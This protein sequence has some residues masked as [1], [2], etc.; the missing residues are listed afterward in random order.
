[1]PPARP[2]HPPLHLAVAALLLSTLLHAASAATSPEVDAL[3]AFKSS[4]AIPPAADP[5]FASWD[6]SA[7]TPCNFTGVTCRGSAVTALSVHDLN[8]SAES[9]PFDVLCGSLKSL[10]TLSLPSNALAGTIAGVDAC[11]GLQELTLPFNSFSGEIPDLSPLTGLRTLNLSTNAFSGSFPWSALAAMPGLQAL[12]AGDNPYLTPTKSFP[13]EITRLTNLTKLYLSAANIAGPIPAGIGRLTRL[14]DLE[15]ADN[16]LTGEIPPAIAQLV[17]LQSLELYNC[18]LAGA[19]PRGFG[20]LTKL[21]FFDASQNQLTGGLSELRSLT[22]LVS[23]Q[24]FY[25][26][27]SGEVPPEFGEFR[28]LVNLSLYNNSL[29]GEL[30]QKL[31]SWSAL[32]FIDVSTNLLTGPIPPDMCRRGTMLK[33]LMLENRFS[34]EIPATYAT[35]TTLQR[36][37]VSKNSLTG[38]VPEGI[39]AL[40]TAEIIDLEGNQFTGGIGDAI[41]KAASLTSLHLAGNKFSGAIPS[42]IGDAAKL[43]SIDVSSNELYGEIPASIGKLVHLESLD[44]AGNGISGAIPASLGS[45]SALSTMNLAGNKLTGAIPSEL[46]GTSLNLLDISSNELSGAV[47]AILAELK[48][49]YLNLSDNRLDG[50]VPAGLAISA[51][52][53]SFQ[54]NPGLCANNGAGFLR[55]CTPGDGG[56]SGSTART[57]VTCLLAGMAVLLAVLGVAIFIKKRRQH[58]EA[59]AMAGAGKLLFAKKGSW[60]VKSFRMMAFDE[61]E[62]VGGVRDENLIGSGGSGNVYRVKLGCGTVVAV[63]HITRT[64]AA[65]AASAGPTAAMLPRSASASARQCREFDAEVGTLSSIRHVNV[66]KL[67]C[68]VTSEDGA[69]SLLVY[70]HLPNGSLYER[71]HGPTARKLG[72]LGW[73]ERYEV[74]VGAARG[75]EYLH[76]GCGDR[77]I[78]HRDVKSSNILLDEA[79]KPR[80]ADFGLAKILDAGGGKQGE[81]WSSSGGAVA[82]TVGYMAPEYAYTR[83]VTE[84]SDVYSF[85]VVLLELATGRA[86]VADGEDVVEWASRRL[87]GAGNGR[88]K[89]MALLDGSAAREEWEK[90]EAVRVLRVAVLC[91]SRTPAVRPSMRSVVQML[92][93]AAVGRECSGNGKPALEVKVVVA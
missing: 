14:V 32:N 56:R 27:L 42:S 36:F 58:A 24:L 54:G 10:A 88:E 12:S 92:E 77:P 6:A 91:T 79:F 89:A 74:A 38:E 31:G 67:L 61:R 65:A 8:V 44:I 70:E 69:A 11:V 18:S 7:A 66:V 57:L 23:L 53:E 50:P 87:D 43:Q 64:R 2:F 4:L 25:N 49:S 5:F 59:A 17:N 76:H 30:P 71:L 22:R 40:P 26:G 52:G 34:G 90:E 55:R 84:K 80:I 48:L 75:L 47:P 86:A 68:S 73:P 20:R 82:G 21:Q 93:D 16:P 62:I 3:M 33:L 15:L 41:G 13:P 78:L 39:W 9:V 83:K 45:C 72:G 60:N 1:M 19:L 37:R 85:G 46:R 29:T 51:Y 28:E 35:C 63:K 81:P